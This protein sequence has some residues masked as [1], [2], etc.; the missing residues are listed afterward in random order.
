MGTKSANSSSS[1]LRPRTGSAS[2]PPPWLLPARVGA[3]A[4]PVMPAKRS[5]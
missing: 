1:V 2:A 5:M 4:P 3:T